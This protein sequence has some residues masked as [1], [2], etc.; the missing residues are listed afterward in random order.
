MLYNKDMYNS[1]ENIPNEEINWGALSVAYY[2][3]NFPQ[4]V[5]YDISIIPP[6]DETQG[7]LSF[8]NDNDLYFIVLSNSN[9]FEVSVVTKYN[10]LAYLIVPQAE[11]LLNFLSSLDNGY[12]IYL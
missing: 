2:I 6:L 8:K 5:K 11:D 9:E 4:L 3:S 1:F 12:K 10:D 7:G